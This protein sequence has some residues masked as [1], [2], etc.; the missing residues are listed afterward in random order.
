MI[1]SQNGE[2]I[3]V[4]LLCEVMSRVAKQ[5]FSFQFCKKIWGQK[6]K[7]KARQRSLGHGGLGDRLLL[8]FTGVNDSC[9]PVIRQNFQ[10]H[11]PAA[12]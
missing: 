8:E 7:V 5:K 6:S 12:D 11:S 1:S 2:K 10:L 4:L 3:S 9:L